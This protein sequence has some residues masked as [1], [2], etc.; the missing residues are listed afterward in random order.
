[1]RAPG[2]NTELEL[3]LESKM[4][5]IGVGREEETHRDL[6][7]SRR[8]RSSY[9]SRSIRQ[10]GEGGGCH[11]EGG[12]GRKAGLVDGSRTFA[13]RETLGSRESFTWLS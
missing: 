6:L 4:F 1:M 9:Q 10:P 5:L 12:V 7:R 11:G 13:I 8:G 3:E 2:R